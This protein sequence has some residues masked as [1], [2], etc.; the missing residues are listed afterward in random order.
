MLILIGILLFM[1]PTVSPQSW[2]GVQKSILVEKHVNP[3][4]TAVDYNWVRTW[5]KAGAYDN[6]RDF[7]TYNLYTP[8]WAGNG[9]EEDIVKGIRMRYGLGDSNL[10]KVYEDSNY[11]VFQYSSSIYTH[12]KP[13]EAPKQTQ[14]QP[15]KQVIGFSM[16]QWTGLILVLIGFLLL[17]KKV[18]W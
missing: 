7:N 14:T 11:Y 15:Q 1:N 4:A 8:V 3:P 2:I 18:M 10:V 12:E 5:D 6:P 13:V 16:M 17:R 9:S